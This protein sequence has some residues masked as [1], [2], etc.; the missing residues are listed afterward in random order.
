MKSTYY[1]ALFFL[2][3]SAASFAQMQ[4]A[5]AYPLVLHDPYFSIWS[6]S[7]TLNAGITRHWT[8]AQQSLRAYIEADGQVYNIMGAEQ[9]HY[10][11]LAATSDEQKYTARFTSSAPAAGWKDIDFD[12]AAW[13]TGA[14]PFTLPLVKGGTEWKTHDIWMRR[15]FT[16]GEEA[17]NKLFVRIAHDDDAEVFLN[18]QKVYSFQGCVRSPAYFAVDPAGQ[19][20]RKGKN[21]LAVHVVNT[22]GDAWMDAGLAYEK[23]MPPSAI[24]QAVQ[25]SVEVKATQTLY[26]F[27]CGSIDA[28]I[29]FT[30]PLLLHDLAL[31]SRPVSYVNFSV[32]SKDGKEHD[33]KLYFVVSSD[34]AVNQPSQEVKCSLGQSG[35]LKI[36]KAGTTAQPVLQKKGDDVRIDWGYLYVA[37]PG[38]DHAYQTITQGEPPVSFK[39]AYTDATPKTG[40]HFNLNTVLPFGKVGAQ[41]KEQF[42]MLGYDDQY[43]IQ[44]FGQNLRPWWKNGT[45]TTIETQLNHAAADYTA[46]IKRCAAFNDSLYAA[47]AKA[48][49]ND[50]AGLCVLAY[51]QSIAAHKLVKSPQGELLFLSK[52]NFSN[53]CINTV[54]VTYPSA[55]LFLLFNPELMKG[56]LNGIFYYS[57]SGKWKKD[58]AAHDLGTYP[59]ANGQVYG[60]DMPVEESGNLLILTAAVCKAEGSTAYAQKHWSVLSRW[61]A[62][63][64]KEGFDPANQL[65]TDDFAGHLSRNANL[66]VKAIVALGCYAK[67]AGMLGDAPTQAKYEAEA[68]NMAKNWALKARL[69][70]HYALTFDKTASWSQKYNLV[71]DKVLDLGLFDPGIYKEEVK[72]YLTKQLPFGLPLDSRKTYTKSDWIMWTAVLADNRPDFDAF[73][74][75]I[76]TY[77][78]Q[79]P[80]RVPLSD[81]HETSNGK[82]VGFQARS[83]VGGYFM[84]MLEEKWAK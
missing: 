41:P 73:I 22:G 63:L 36:I 52:E 4:K 60:E 68:K 49:G 43:S 82:Q 67:L 77:A 2:L 69:D 34:L 54:D 78:T 53:G 61:A 45:D 37:V 29:T 71:W 16:A 7:D 13:Q 84:K 25:R 72:Y 58:F 35:A 55:P 17:F 81:W 28:T 40:R 65:C 3:C 80:S 51:A 47:A 24:K 38:K 14:A 31:L 57:E 76:Y 83:V 15:T 44:F 66:S 48:G 42:V 32:Q 19:G 33:V 46:T 75:P 26:R 39:P 64:L 20:L 59:K 62:Y 8:G 10:V 23:K 21:V 56:M 11:P 12:D 79:T 30:S 18:G 74:H 50:Y 6:F 70:D 1:F 5:P 9:P 27:D